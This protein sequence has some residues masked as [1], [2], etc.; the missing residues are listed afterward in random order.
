MRLSRLVLQACL[1][2]ALLAFLGLL[3]VPRFTNYDVMIVRGSSMEPT[4]HLGS[5][6]VVDRSTRTLAIG[7]AAAFRDPSGETVTHRVVALDGKTY[8]TRGDA[9][10]AADAEHRSQADVI[11]GALFSIPYLG[12]VLFVMQQPWAF[13][14]LLAITGGF[15]IF[16][17]LR[18]M[19]TEIRRLVTN[20]RVMQDPP[21]PVAR[22]ESI[23]QAIEGGSE[24]AD[25]TSLA[26]TS[27]TLNSQSFPTAT[28]KL[29]APTISLVALLV[30][31]AVAFVMRRSRY[32]S[33]HGHRIEADR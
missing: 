9:N 29:P 17:E 25:T 10:P 2:L 21:E 5:A 12:Y 24:L 3:A 11:G 6:V 4:I 26:A 13:L 28:P 14:A 31:A 15:L 27:P 33:R 8:V 7:E 1:W 30:L 32:M 20:R 18:T 16:S 19:W 23:R 22:S